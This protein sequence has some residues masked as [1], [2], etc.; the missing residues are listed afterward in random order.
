[1]GKIESVDVVRWQDGKVHVLGRGEET[2][3]SDSVKSIAYHIIHDASTGKV[4]S[5]ESFMHRGSFPLFMCGCYMLSCE[6]DCPPILD[7][8]LAVNIHEYLIRA[9]HY[10]ETVKKF[11]D[12][13]LKDLKCPI[14]VDGGK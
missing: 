1:M 2:V 12:A 7:R 3:S 11:R 6:G 14:G 9:K 13:N 8:D 5:E 10:D 4:V